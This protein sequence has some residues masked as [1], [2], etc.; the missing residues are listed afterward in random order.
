METIRVIIE[1]DG[2]T[3]KEVNPIQIPKRITGEHVYI[4]SLR[5][6]E[7]EKK[8]SSLRVF[9]IENESYCGSKEHVYSDKG[10]GNYIH[11]PVGS[12]HSAEIID[13]N[14]VKII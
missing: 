4:H 5:I 12:T 6:K 3:A 14:T 10:Q 7:Y 13:K 1:P 11:I 9:K 2:I 8:K